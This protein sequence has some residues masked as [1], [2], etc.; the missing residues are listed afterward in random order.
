M[1]FC[2]HYIKMINL[3]RWKQ[4]RILQRLTPLR[5]RLDIVILS[6]RDFML[7]RLVPVSGDFHTRGNDKAKAYMRQL[8]K[9][10]F[11]RNTEKG[12]TTQSLRLLKRK[13]SKDRDQDQD[14]DCWEICFISVL[15]EECYSVQM[16]MKV[17]T[18]SWS[19][20]WITRNRLW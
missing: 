11:W 7:K 17:S 10:R 6:S 12:L 18:R 2:E 19:Y 1:Y 16:V 3:C 14:Q 13:R 8:A 4:I 20:W 5:W 9:A 15:I